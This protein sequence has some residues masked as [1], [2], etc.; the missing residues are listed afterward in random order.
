M[1]NI[2][3][4]CSKPENKYL[5]FFPSHTVSPLSLPFLGVAVLPGFHLSL[6]VSV[7][8]SLLWWDHFGSDLLSSIPRKT[9]KP[10]L[11]ST[12]PP[13][14]C[15]PTYHLKWKTNRSVFSSLPISGSQEFL[16]L[17]SK[18]GHVFKKLYFNNILRSLH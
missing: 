7:P 8:I 10:K 13:T 2:F 12:P 15:T 3:L 4:I 9:F 18:F 16:Y 11:C 1:G 6:G 5:T 17:S 14:P